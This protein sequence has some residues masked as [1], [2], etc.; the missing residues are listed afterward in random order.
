MITQGHFATQGP[1]PPI[2]LIVESVGESIVYILQER[3]SNSVLAGVGVCGRAHSYVRRGTMGSRDQTVLV[4]DA[5]VGFHPTI[6]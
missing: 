1:P 4:L 2:D 6:R 3:Y 5:H